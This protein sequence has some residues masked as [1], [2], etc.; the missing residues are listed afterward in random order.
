M[1]LQA[2]LNWIHKELDNV[3]DPELIEAIKEMLKYR[4]KNT[5][6]RISIEQYNKEIEEAERDIENG[7]YYTQEEVEKMAKEWG[8]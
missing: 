1:N 7:N 3:K 8:R 6:E 5:Q 2:D 4:K